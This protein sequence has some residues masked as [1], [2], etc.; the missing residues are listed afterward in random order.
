MTLDYSLFRAVFIIGFISFCFLCDDITIGFILHV[1]KESISFK[2]VFHRVIRVKMNYS[3]GKGRLSMYQFTTFF[4]V[5]FEPQK[6][7]CILFICSFKFKIERYV[8]HFINYYFLSSCIYV[9]MN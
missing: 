1:I 7:L 5:I 4:L 6:C 9:I 2:F 8:I 3:A